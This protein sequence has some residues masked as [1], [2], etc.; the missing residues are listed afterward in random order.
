MRAGVSSTDPPQT[1]PG[2][3]HKS[4]DSDYLPS[5]PSSERVA[6]SRCITRSMANHCRS[7]EESPSPPHTDRSN[8]DN[9]PAAQGRKRGFSQVSSSSTSQQ[10]SSKRS[11]RASTRQQRGQ[12][13]QHTN[14]FCT[15]RCLLGLR[16]GG[17]LDDACSNVSL[18][19]QGP[20]G[21]QHRINAAQ[22]V[23]M[24]KRQLDRDPN[25]YCRPMGS[26]GSYGA[27]FKITCAT[28]GY[29]ILGKGTTSWIWEEVSR[30]VEIYR[31]LQR[32]QGS[33]VP[34][35]L[36]TIDMAHIYFL[37]GAGR[38]Q[39]MLLIG[40]AGKKLHSVDAGSHLSRD[41]SRSKEQLRLCGV[42]HED[43]MRL[44]NM[45]WTEELSRVL[46]IDFHRCRIDR[47]PT[48]ERVRSLKTKRDPFWGRWTGRN[49][50]GRMQEQ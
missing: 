39:H 29:T 48:E 35:F 11:T 7:P 12:G 22:L 38:I 24:L 21:D 43:L 2:S 47:R 20:G 10:A 3:D 50:S 9:V 1:T 46:I 13:R 16:Q 5:S 8:S 41:I 45:L 36:G 44:D 33:A 49:S 40:W 23:Q 15:Q 6:E 32:V 26:C 30:E 17:R 28:Y 37:H 14:R 34:V 31:I 42:V 18:H 25:H 19:R 27:P 4:S